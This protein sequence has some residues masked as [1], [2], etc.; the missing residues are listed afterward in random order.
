[1]VIFVDTSAVLP[2][3]NANDPDHSSANDV[4]RRHLDS[5]RLITHNYVVVETTALVQRRFGMRGVRLFV[6]RLLP[7]IEV[8]WIDRARH[9]RAMAS[10]LAGGRR[11]ISF[12]DAVSFDLMRELGMQDAFAYDND[13]GREGFTLLA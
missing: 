13:F 12:V 4:L 8:F 9:D 3:L 10:L 2:L 1:M 7:R 11:G 5:A 6:E